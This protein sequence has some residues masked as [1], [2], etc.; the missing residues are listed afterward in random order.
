MEQLKDAEKTER[1]LDRMRTCVDIAVA[2][3]QARSLPDFEQRVKH[4]LGN[5]FAVN[6]VRVLFYEADTNE[7]LISSAQM[8]RKGLSRLGLDKGVVGLCAKKQQVVHVAN[9][10][11]HPYIDAAADGL[12]RSG[13]PISSESSMLV[14]P[15][16]IENVEGPRLVG[17]VQLLERRKVKETEREAAQSEKKGEEFSTE[18]QSLFTQL[19]RVCAQAA[20]R[21]YLVQELTG[22]V[23]NTPMSLAHMLSQ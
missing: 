20:W 19:L 23:N 11:H 10:S 7:L 22:K 8:R 5:F 12:Q 18:E 15:L 16:V 4:L 14:G 17:V 13:R 9:I 21:T 3:N 1:S 2:I 6:T